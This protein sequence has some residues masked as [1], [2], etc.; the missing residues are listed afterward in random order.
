MEVGA[1]QEGELDLCVMS[2]SVDLVFVG[3]VGNVSVCAAG[4]RP[5]GKDNR[6]DYES[7]SLVVYS[8][9]SLWR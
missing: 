8:R 5:N 3:C 2:V 6:E 1:L 9:L 7:V 4:L